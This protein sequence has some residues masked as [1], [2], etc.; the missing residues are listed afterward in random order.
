MVFL[1]KMEKQTGFI[2][3]AA[4]LN[5]PAVMDILSPVAVTVM[6]V[7]NWIRKTGS[8]EKKMRELLQQ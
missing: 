2:V 3:V 6:R 4:F 8:R 5:V 1:P 7:K